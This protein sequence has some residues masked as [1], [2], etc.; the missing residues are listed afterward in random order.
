MK[1]EFKMVESR[2]PEGLEQGVN[3]LLGHGWRLHGV[4]ML[5]TEPGRLGTAGMNCRFVQ[6][7]V[8]DH[9]ETGA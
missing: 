6:A 7:L 3:L 2:T 1:Q 8:H 4:T 9:E 5:A